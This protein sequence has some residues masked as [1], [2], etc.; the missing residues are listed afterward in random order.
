MTSKM[1]KAFLFFICFSL[2]AVSCTHA[3]T[4]QKSNGGTDTVAAS[5]PLCIGGNDISKYTVVYRRTD[6]YNVLNRLG[7]LIVN[8]YDFDRLSAEKLAVLIYSKFGIR[9][10]VKCDDWCDESEYEILVGRTNRNLHPT[11]LTE[12]EY[13]IRTEGKKLVV[14]GGSYGST[15]HA[16]DDLENWIAEQTG[17]GTDTLDFTAAHN[18]DSA[19]DVKVIACIGDSITYGSTSTDP[20][21]LSYPANLQR[22]LWKDYIVYN[23]GR[24]GKTMRDDLEDSYMATEEYRSCLENPIGYDLV[25]IMLGTNDSAR[26]PLWTSSDNAQFTS[27]CKTMI[28]AIQAKNGKAK[29]VLMNCPAYYGNGTAGSAWVLNA[30]KKTFTELYA[31]GYDLTFYDMNRFTS[32]EMGEALFPDTLHPSDVGYVKMAV[33]VRDLVISIMTDQANQYIVSYSN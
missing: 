2:L 1:L 7:D 3:P 20:A 25:L 29:F 17:S 12:D 4:D 22:L 15:W 18:I 13:V 8:D 23:Y 33:G 30:Q 14:C 27:S 5:E 26:D 11:D 24:G 21:Y 32:T 9:L 19:Y 6:Y 31:S 10:D 28:D 16:I